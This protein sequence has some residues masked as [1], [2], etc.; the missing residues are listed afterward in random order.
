MKLKLYLVS[1][2]ITVT[3]FANELGVS[4]NHLN[5]IVNERYKCGKS[6]AFKIEIKTGGEIKVED[7]LNEKELA[8]SA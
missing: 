5:G 8:C 7:L 6:L 3:E 4:R 1:K 2:K